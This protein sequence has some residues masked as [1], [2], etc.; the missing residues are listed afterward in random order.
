M[1]TGIYLLLPRG[2]KLQFS[3]LPVW[4]YRGLPQPQVFIG[5]TFWQKILTWLGNYTQALTGGAVAT[6]LTVSSFV[7]FSPDSDTAGN[8]PQAVQNSTRN[9]VSREKQTS[10]NNFESEHSQDN[11]S[12]NR[13]NYNQNQIPVISST[14][15]SRNEITANSQNSVINESLY[16]SNTT[17]SSE[18]DNII[19]IAENSTLNYKPGNSSP[20]DI[21]LRKNNIN[22]SRIAPV[23]KPA[24]TD[25]INMPEPLGYDYPINNIK[26]GI[27]LSL[28]VKVIQ[29]WDLNNETIW[30]A[31]EQLFNNFSF[32][33]F[34][35]VYDRFHLGLDIRRENFYQKFAGSENNREFDYEQQPNFTTYDL[36]FRYF[37]KKYYIFNPFAELSVGGNSIGFVGRLQ[38]GFYYS[39]VSGINFVFGAQYNSMYYSHQGRNYNS[40]KISL[41]SGVNFKL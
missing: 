20:A 28:E 14:S 7:L 15:E 30:P 31:Q 1:P 18:N 27:P 41:N 40:G 10:L 36:N 34:Y 2:L 4:P 16:E 11:I 25:D 35:P 3:L 17:H 5:T 24:V 37:T 19:S 29:D 32:A 38:A 9:H 6:I 22:V 13:G 23:I 21:I 39:P 12:G 33:I 26:I 8:M